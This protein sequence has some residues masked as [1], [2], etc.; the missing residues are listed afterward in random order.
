M[1]PSV[2]SDYPR[3]GRLAWGAALQSRLHPALGITILGPIE[4]FM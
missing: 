1:V 3:D 2:P 4:I